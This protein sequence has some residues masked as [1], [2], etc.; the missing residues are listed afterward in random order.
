M[1]LFQ[2]LKTT[3]WKVKIFLILLIIASGYFGVSK[4]VS[5]GSSKVT[6]QTATAEKGTLITNVSASGNI[7][8]GGMMTITTQ[9][10]GTVSTVY[11]KNGDTVTKG[12]KIADIELDQ[13]G[14]QRQA[15]AW[16]SYLSCTKSGQ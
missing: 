16:S 5:A 7:S 15:Q 12:Q 13:D 9:A 8:N 2:T 10:T 3:S 4:I 1:N 6:Y 11:V 14:Q